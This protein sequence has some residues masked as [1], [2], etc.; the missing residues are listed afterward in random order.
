MKRSN[1]YRAAFAR[2]RWGAFA[3]LLCLGLGTAASAQQKG[4]GPFD[5]DNARA[6]LRDMKDDIKSNYY[7]PNFRGMNLDEHFKEADEKLKQATTRDQLMLVIAQAVLDFNDSHLFFAPPSRAADFEYG[8]Q[9]QM[10]GDAC[11]ITAVKPKTDAG[12]QGLKPG[13]T[14]LSV[15]GFRPTRDNLWKMYYRYYALMPARSIRLVV[16]SPGEAKPRQL[17]VASKIKKRT[18]AI[19]YD[20]F[21]FRLLREDYFDEKVKYVE[22]GKDVFVWKMKSFEADEKHVDVMMGKAKSFKTLILDLRGNGGGAQDTLKRL[23]SYFFDHDVTVATNKKRKES[24]PIIAKTR[25][26][27]MFKGNL[28]VLV[29]SNSASAAEMF[30]RIIQLEKRGTVMGD[31]TM[32]AVM[33]ANWFDHQTGN[34]DVFFYGASVTVADVL[35]SDGKSLENV[36]VTPD[37]V[38]LPTGADLA[39]QRDPVLAH[40]CA[41]AGAPVDAEKAG[42]FFPYEWRRTP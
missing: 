15:D 36:G 37:E 24:K 32:G 13:D 2:M 7:D 38:M 30:A 35:M 10:F 5:R 19:Q 27:D 11:Y 31:K 29:D 17:D 23:V 1:D 4:L 26:G 14:V 18:A 33:A 21:F 16:Q 39:S 8:W 9:M 20:E 34:G 41:L 42:T 28:I 22:A 25:G 6:M 3:V 12:A 40:A